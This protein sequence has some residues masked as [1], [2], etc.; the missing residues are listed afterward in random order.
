MI[1]FLLNISFK[2]PEVF[3]L[4][5]ILPL[6]GIIY[7]FRNAAHF[8]TLKLSSLIAFRN[9]PSWRGKFRLLL[10]LFR[11]LTFIALV[12]ALARPQELLKEQNIKA[13]G[14]DIFLAMDLSWS[15]LAQDFKPNRLESSKRIAASFVDRRKYDRI[16]LAVFAAE[17]FTQCPLTSDHR[18]LKEFL[19]SLQ[20]GVLKDGTAI[21]MGLAAA[22]NR[23]KD[24]AAKSKVVILLTDGDNNS[25]YIKPMT[26]TEI[27]KEFGIKVYT[28]GI[29]SKGEALM[30]I[31]KLGNGQYI[32]DKVPVVFDEALLK[33]IAEITGGKY[34]RA[35]SDQSLER[36]YA[37]I[38]QLEKTELEVTSIKRE[39][40]AFH[41]FALLAIVLLALEISMRYTIFRTIP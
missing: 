26:A 4:L 3:F 33:K 39:S 37:E 17:A 9:I 1:D 29:G 31:Q 5:L 28:I 30:P 34:F 38:D 16:G 41:I 6:I 21:G 36:I 7:A 32:Y 35:T 22:V 2:N 10:P 20:Y 11:I 19:A 40:E 13:E 24:G 27:A 15:M 12:T 23:I 8:A 25:G 14:I 18:V